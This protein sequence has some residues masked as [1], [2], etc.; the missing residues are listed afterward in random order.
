MAKVRVQDATKEL[1]ANVSNL[2]DV[3][4]KSHK[5]ALDLLSSLKKLE[6]TARQKE[7]ERR[8]QEEAKKQEEIK[9][10]EAAAA[11]GATAVSAGDI[12]LEL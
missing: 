5:R 9:K 4:S 2:Y 3:V 11:E 1:S 12:T 8:M 10:Q 7:I 6:E